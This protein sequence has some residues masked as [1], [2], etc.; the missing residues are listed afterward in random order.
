MSVEEIRVLQVNMAS[1]GE[2]I[3]AVEVKLNFLLAQAVLIIS[4]LVGL[5]MK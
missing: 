2:R 3:K 5:L 4:G 1:M